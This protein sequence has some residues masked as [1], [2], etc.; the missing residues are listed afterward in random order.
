MGDMMK[1]EPIKFKDKIIGYVI[2]ESDTLKH[3]KSGHSFVFDID[4]WQLFYDKENKK[5]IID[6]KK[7]TTVW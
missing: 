5:M 7:R 6:R 2:V 4:K 1:K 3:Q